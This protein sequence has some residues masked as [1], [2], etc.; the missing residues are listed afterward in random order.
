[1]VGGLVGR[2]VSG[3]W[4]VSRWSVCKWSVGKWSVDLIKPSEPVAL[5][6]FKAIDKRF[7]VC[8]SCCGKKDSFIS[9]LSKIMRKRFFSFHN[10][11]I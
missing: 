10:F 3:R 6:G 7:Y 11:F 5:F 9:S 8:W 1:M 4:S 2:W